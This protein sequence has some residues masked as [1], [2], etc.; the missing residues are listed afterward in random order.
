MTTAR[1]MT[2]NQGE[3]SDAQEINSY[4]GVCHLIS[5]SLRAD[6]M[7]I[8]ALLSSTPNRKSPTSTRFR[9]YLRPHAFPRLETYRQVL[10]TLLLTLSIVS[11]A[12]F[13]PRDPQLA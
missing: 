2:V 10:S 8:T 12:F 6:T 3:E 13:V 1:R 4:L 5:L 7:C 9:L 11:Y